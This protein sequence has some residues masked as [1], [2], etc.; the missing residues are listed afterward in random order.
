MYISIFIYIYI[1][2]YTGLEIS[3]FESQNAKKNLSQMRNTS[4]K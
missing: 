3:G 2:R 4:A 1:C